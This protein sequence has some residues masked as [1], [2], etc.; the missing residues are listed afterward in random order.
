LADLNRLFLILLSSR[1]IVC[2]F[3]FIY[4]K[5]DIKNQNSTNFWPFFQTPSGANP[6]PDNFAMEHS[7]NG[8]VNSF[9]TLPFHRYSYY[10]LFLKI[11][12]VHLTTLDPPYFL[13]IFFQEI[14]FRFF[15]LNLKKD[16]EQNL[17][18]IT[19]FFRIMQKY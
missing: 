11:S 3:S 7:E 9:F 5:F 16:G 15:F 6:F 1:G 19:I 10:E 4:S 2:F 14:F 8:T 18:Y 17:F 13:E 12:S